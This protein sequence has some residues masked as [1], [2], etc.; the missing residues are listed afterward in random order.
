MYSGYWVRLA[1]LSLGAEED[2][3]HEQ[4]TDTSQGD[5]I[6]GLNHFLIDLE[7]QVYVM[8]QGGETADSWYRSL[9]E[10]GSNR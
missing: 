6:V 5:Q 2:D 10:N 9:G 1:S 8:C 4:Q 3:S 7:R